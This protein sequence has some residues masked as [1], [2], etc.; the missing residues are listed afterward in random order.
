MTSIAPLEA[1]Q[2]APAPPVVPVAPVLEPPAAAVPAALACPTTGGR[3]NAERRVVVLGTTLT[4]RDVADVAIGHA[5]V[6]VDRAAVHA[7][8][9]RARAVVQ[10]TLDAGVPTYGLNRGLGP[11]RDSEIPPEM[12]GD[13][14]RY[15]IVS[16]AAAIGEP[17]SRIEG[18]AA[19]L[20]RLNT[21]AAGASGAS[22]GLFDG[23]LALLHND[24]V[25]AIP[26]QG[27]VGAG[28]LSQ[29]AAIG[30]VLLGEG[31]AW[32]P[33]D[34]RIASGAEALAVAGLSPLRLAAKDSLALVGSNAIS[35]ATAALTQRRAT[36]IAE[37]ADLVAALTV[38]ALGANLSPFDRAALAA[39]PHAGQQASGARIRAAVAGGDLARGRR[40]AT[41]VQDA[42]SLRTVPQV[43]GA[44]LDQ[45]DQLEQLLNVELN[46]APDNPFLDLERGS[47]VSNGNFSITNLA[48]GFDALRIAL[49]HQ[50]L[51]AERR[52]ALLVRQLRQGLPLASQVR[53]VSDATGYVT[54]VILAQT[55]SALVA[56]AKHLASPISLTG[57][58]VG[59]GVEDHSSMA[60]PSVR[61]TE[62]VLDVVEQLLAVE[63]LLAATVIS[64]H[65]GRPIVLGAPVER[66]RAAIIEVTGRTQVTAEVIDWVIEAL[67][68]ERR[69][70]DL[71]EMRA[72][73]VRPSVANHDQEVAR[74]DQ[75]H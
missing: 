9:A 12:I 61:A 75:L 49:A 72:P 38:E 34:D 52:V 66:L 67:R 54:P 27:S 29:L 45:L 24:V 31:R 46:C 40:G 55:A 7:R 62:Q 20:A 51:L 63:A 22:V 32:L 3:M 36:L 15:V 50:A 4:P 25:P 43:H 56:R 23:L 6:A 65:E 1:A 13:F 30:L 64:V 2:A 17:L 74:H 60:Y 41:S 8:L 21:L 69:G 10:A 18:R 44:L 19:L 70:D 48:I 35:V 68:R 16:H 28:D 11:L 39:R 73:R 37:R 47:F 42:V 58:T 57:T 14:Q 53:A 59:D 5:V 33:G 71:A 26:D